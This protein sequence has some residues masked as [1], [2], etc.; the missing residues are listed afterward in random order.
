MAQQ[1]DDTNQG[2]LHKAEKNKETDRDYSGSLNVVCPKC[3]Q[4]TDFW[5][6]S[7]INTAKQT[8][9]KYLKISV[10]PKD[11]SPPP[12]ERREDSVPAGYVAAP[13]RPIRDDDIPF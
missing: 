8:G 10:K 12:R 1:Y 3:G 4:K 7:W 9:K 5:L 6:S 13:A 2:A 11:G